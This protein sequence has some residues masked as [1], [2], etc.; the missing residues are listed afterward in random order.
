MFRHHLNISWRNILK[1]KTFSLLNIGGLTLGMTLTFLISLWVYDELSFDRFHANYQEIYQVIANRNFNDNVFTDRNMLFPL[2]KAIDAE[3]PDVKDAVWTTHLQTSLLSVDETSLNKQGLVVGGPIFDIFSWHFLQGNAT[4]ALANPACIVLTESTAL[5]LFGS[6]DPLDKII[7][8]DNERDMKVTAIISDPPANSSLTFDYLM[9]F[10][11]SSPAVKKSMES[12]DNYSWYVYVQANAHTDIAKL[13]KE[14]T[15][16]MFR[17][18]EDALSTYFVFPMEKWHLHGQFKDGVSTGG[19]IRYVRLFAIIALIILLIACINYMNLSTARSETRSLEVAVRKTLGSE[20]SQLIYQ[21]LLETILLSLL[22]FLGTIIVIYFLLPSF[23]LLV[24]KQISLNLI[25]PRLWLSGLGIILLTGFLAGSYPALYLSSFEPIKVL[26]GSIK[27]GSGII[28]PRRIL[29][30]FQFVA[31][32]ALISATIIVQQQIKFIKQRDLG[33]DPDNLIVIPTNSS[34][35]RNYTAIKNRLKESP[36]IN[37]VTR[38]SSSLT[39]IGWGFPAPDWPDKDSETN[40]LFK[41]MTADQDFSATVGTKIVEGREFTGMPSDSTSILLNEAALQAMKLKDP[42]GKKVT[43]FGPD[44]TIIGILQDI[45]MESPF[46]TVEPMMVFYGNSYN[47]IGIRLAENVDPSS[48]LQEIES[49]FKEFSPEHPFEYQFVDQEFAKKLGSLELI[50]K[51]INIFAGLAILICCL[52]M[53]G[54][55]SFMIAKRAKEMAVRKVLGAS[56]EQLLLLISHE[57]ITLVG[58]A[59]ALAV[60]LTYWLVDDWLLQFEL[61]ISISLWIFLYVGIGAFLLTVIVVGL[62]TIKAALASP[63]IAL[64]SE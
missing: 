20:R 7:H 58:I 37:S 14:I 63:I 34:N 50:N 52:G 55:A 62:N 2:A 39:S 40:I 42:L 22:A 18:T 60:P 25:S 36:L 17:H 57:F 56:L 24:D 32:I 41:G 5:A 46:S 38:S 23:N 45:V 53:A 1:N 31:S 3:I 30:I 54:L 15:D 44:L 64:K 12:W 9:P 28:L 33:Y 43:G 26:K 4:D 6:S 47:Y 21:F 8:V 11:F 16:L 27:Q 59:L 49:T 51:L 19:A 61:H 10:D 29:V 48:A 35:D 13:E